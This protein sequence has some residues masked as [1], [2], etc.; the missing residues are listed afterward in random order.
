MNSPY[1][2]VAY[3]TGEKND[4]LIND[5]PWSNKKWRSL[6]VVSPNCIASIKNYPYQNEELDMFVLNW[7]KELAEINLGWKYDTFRHYDADRDYDIIFKTEYM[8]NDFGALDRH[9]MYISNS[10]TT[11][12]Q[13]SINYSGKS[14]CMYC[15]KVD[16][17]LEEE[18]FLQCNECNPIF[19]CDMCDKHMSNYDCSWVVDEKG[20]IISICPCCYEQSTV[21]FCH[22]CDYDTIAHL[23][24]IYIPDGETPNIASRTY[25]VCQRC[26]Q[27]SF[28]P[29]L[30][31][32]NGKRYCSD[33]SFFRWRGIKKLDLPIK[34]IFQ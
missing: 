7:I 1:V 34:L 17:Y 26:V 30:T 27:E 25:C 21:S 22:E 4:F 6:Y 23:V 31:D 33:R 3:L 16:I 24:P 11:E 8:Y 15:G 14:Q 19:Y 9:F 32:R 5:T 18:H 12:D 2:V 10:F 20:D 28:I 13:C 29:T